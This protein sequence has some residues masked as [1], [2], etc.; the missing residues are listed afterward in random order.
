ML[1][2]SVDEFED[3][4]LKGLKEDLPTTSASE[5]SVLIEERRLKVSLTGRTLIVSI[6]SDPVHVVATVFQLQWM[7]LHSL[8]YHWL[9]GQ[10]ITNNWI[11]FNCKIFSNSVG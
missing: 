10:N 4:L 6:S 11:N 7:V 9:S 1:F 5:T 8:T 3:K 2:P